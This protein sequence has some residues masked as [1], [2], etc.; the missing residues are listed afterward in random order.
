M[1]EIFMDAK[2]S[3]AIRG[4]AHQISTKTTLQ[5]RSFW[6]MKVFYP[7]D[8]WSLSRFA[9]GVSIFVCFYFELRRVLFTHTHTQK[10]HVKLFS[11]PWTNPEILSYPCKEPVN[12][13]KNF[14]RDFFCLWTFFKNPLVKRNL[15]RE[16][17]QNWSIHGC[18]SFHGIKNTGPTQVHPQGL[19]IKT[20]FGFVILTKLVVRENNLIM[21]YMC[22]TNWK[23][24]HDLTIYG[25]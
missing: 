3:A 25:H 13:F 20:M 8:V 2:S 5:E 18:F 9:C 1:T 23:L 11:C 24:E 6:L 21:K 17:F 19:I 22:T 4:R 16:H 7:P 10:S 12:I 14:S 15:A